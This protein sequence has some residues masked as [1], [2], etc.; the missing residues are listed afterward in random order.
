MRA[1]GVA[2]G[3]LTESVGRTV[4]YGW[5][6]QSRY[7]REGRGERGRE[8]SKGLKGKEGNRGKQ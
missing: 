7:G 8:R 1:V 3:V 4:C 5:M 6:R 2:V